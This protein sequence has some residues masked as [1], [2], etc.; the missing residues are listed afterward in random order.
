MTDIPTLIPQSLYNRLKKL[1]S[2]STFD[3][4]WI[5]FVFAIIGFVALLLLAMGPIGYIIGFVML[6][7]LLSEAIRDAVVDVLRRDFATL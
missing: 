7:T 3:I 4:L 6:S 2:G 1:V 5:A